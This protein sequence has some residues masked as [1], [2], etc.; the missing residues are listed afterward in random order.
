MPLTPLDAQV[1]VKDEGTPVGS[2]LADE[3][4]FVGGGVTVT[5]VALMSSTITTRPSAAKANTLSAG[6]ADSSL[7]SPSTPSLRVTLASVSWKNT[8]PCGF[9]ARLS[10]APPALLTSCHVAS[11]SRIALSNTFCVLA[12]C[13]CNGLG[14][15]F[16]RKRIASG[17]IAVACLTLCEPMPH[18]C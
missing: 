7:I 6:I 12:V 8:S 1:T 15:S 17:K 4:D 13:A 16:Q 9:T 3:L 2:E 5:Q 18:T 11:G 10:Q 14:Q